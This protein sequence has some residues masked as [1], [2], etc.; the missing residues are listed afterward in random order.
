MVSNKERQERESY[1]HNEMCKAIKEHERKKG[2]ERSGESIERE[3]Q[4]IARDTE[5]KKINKIYQR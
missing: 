3:V 2:I 4:Q 1:A 5:A